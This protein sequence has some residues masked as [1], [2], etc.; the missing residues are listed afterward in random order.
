M[1]PIRVAALLISVAVFSSINAMAVQ[2][3]TMEVKQDINYEVKK[4]D[5]HYAPAN[6][7]GVPYYSV[8]VYYS[9][10]YFEHPSY[11]Y[12]PHLA[13]ASLGLACSTFTPYTL[14]YDEEWYLSQPKYAREFFG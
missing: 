7:G 11:E 9:R 3:N 14:I 12:D 13:S 2:Q 6:G 5:C 1:K 10:N 4:I 8:D